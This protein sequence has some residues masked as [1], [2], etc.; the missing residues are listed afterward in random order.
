[1]TAGVF[2]AAG[3]TALKPG[4]TVSMADDSLVNQQGGS[5]CIAYVRIGTDGNVYESDADGNFGASSQTWLTSG[6]SSDVW[7]EFTLNSGDALTRDTTSG[8]RTNL[9]SDQE[10]GY[11]K[12]ITTGL[13]TGSVTVDFYNAASG[14][15]LLD[16]ATYN[17]LTAELT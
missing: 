14:G 4:V 7:V 6:S 10:F 15:S 11:R 5:L 17:P 3:S 16:T 9:G 8:A 13:L 2:S 12:Q 1:M